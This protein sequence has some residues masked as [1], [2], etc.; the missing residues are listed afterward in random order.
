[1]FLALVLI[2]LLGAITGAGAFMAYGVYQVTK[3]RKKR[4]DLVEEIKKEAAKLD[5]RTTSIK[6]RLTKAS[7]LAQAQ[8]DLRNA[9]EQPSKNATHSKYKNGVISEINDL[10]QQ[11]LD[12]LR[13]ILAEGF[14][15]IITVVQDGGMKEEIPLSEY[16][17]S[18]QQN[19]DAAM[20]SR[21]DAPLPPPKPPTTQ[22]NN[23]KQMGKFF[24]YKGGKPDGTTH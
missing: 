24:V 15:P 19:M 12:I 11:K 13:T 9:A 7:Q 5:E 16:V 14:N 23:P 3:F 18:A 1:M 20:G 17:T 6:E 21:K 10:E 22:D 4:S 8:M 2:F